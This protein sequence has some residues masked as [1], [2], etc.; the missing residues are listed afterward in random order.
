MAATARKTGTIPAT[1][2][3][4]VIPKT[5]PAGPAIAMETGIRASETKKSRLETRPRKP[6]W[7]PALEQGAPDHHRGRVGRA[8][9][10]QGGAHDPKCQPPR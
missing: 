8:Y 2:K 7:H 3:T 10:E 4:A 5:A 9:D 6:L 1:M